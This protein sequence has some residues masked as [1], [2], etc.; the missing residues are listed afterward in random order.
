ML[1]RDDVAPRLAASAP[2]VTEA[3]REAWRATRVRAPGAAHSF[4][5]GTSQAVSPV[6]DKVELWRRAYRRASSQGSK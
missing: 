5:G 4:N 1:W 2:A 3:E 6:A